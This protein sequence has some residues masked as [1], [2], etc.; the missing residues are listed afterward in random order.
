MRVRSR[1]AVVAAAAIFGLPGAAYAADPPIGPVTAQTVAAAQADA[2][3]AATASTSAAQAAAQA[4]V[5]LNNAIAAAQAAAAA[6]SSNPTPENVAAAAA[7]SAAQ[8]AA[9]TD[10]NTKSAAAATAAAAATDAAAKAAREAESFAR[11]SKGTATEGTTEIADPDPFPD[12]ALHSDNVTVVG[13]VRGAWSQNITG[14]PQ[15]QNPAYCPAFNLT[16]CPGFSSLNFVHFENLGY[17]VM[18]ANGT[19]GLSV[20]SLKD[21]A[22]PKWIS[23]V[24]PAQM[25]AASGQTLIRFWEGENM[26]T[27][28]RRKLVFMSRDEGDKGQFIID[29]NDPWHPAIVNYSKTRQGHTSTCI[30]DCRFLWSVGGVQSNSGPTAP[31][32]PV[33]ISDIR[34]PVHPFV[35]PLFGADLRRGGGSAGSTHSVDVDFDGVVWVSGNSGVRGFYT[36]GVHKDPTTGQDRLATPYNPI[37]YGGAPIAGNDT[38][39]P[40]APRNDPNLPYTFMHNAYRFP[41]PLGGRAAGDLM[42]ITNENNS[43]DCTT[44]GQFVIASL[45]GTRD[46]TDNVTTNTRMQRLS[47]Y[48]TTGQPGVFQ[49][50]TVTGPRQSDGAP[51]TV[52]VGDCS[53]HWF[54]VKGNIVAL[55]NYEQ[56]TRFLDISDPTNP[57]QI[58]WYRVPVRTADPSGKPDIISSDTAGAYWHGKYVYV[59][60]YQRG[61]DILK[62]DDADMRGKIEPKACWNSC[63]ADSQVV[64][65]L[66][67]SATGTAGGTVAATLSLTLGT[68]A[69]FGAFTPGVGKDYT[70]SM[71]AN[72]ISTAGNAGLSVAD[73]ASNAT[74]HLVNGTFSL[75]S[76]LQAKASSPLGTGGALADVGGS[77]NPTPLLAYANPASNDAVK[78]DFQQHVSANDALRTGSYSKTLTFTLSTTAP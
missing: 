8:A 49:G 47:A 71:T 59:A 20:W 51:T 78:V 36:E 41:N 11:L 16:K 37:S 12:N 70:S 5:V 9:Q 65:P 19:A 60:D 67:V 43:T 27:D 56:G 38:W 3:A 32:S 52:A 24:T 34:D 42:L 15:A 55:G 58:G 72:V 26:T 64:D 57:K 14:V 29:I 25:A 39:S 2:T 10:F 53:A 18:V 21:P 54:T 31:Q 77:A 17:D 46:A 74:G 23:Q 35:Y 30:N 45:S 76:V 1:V 66:S 73:G 50:S 22:H 6:A 75:P 62:L 48:R 61:I 13:H 44:A 69:S 33:S 68:P 7:A 4:Q 28:T 40:P 63:S